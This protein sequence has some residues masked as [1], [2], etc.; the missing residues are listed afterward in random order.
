MLLLLERSGITGLADHA[1][2]SPVSQR[3]T[4]RLMALSDPTKPAAPGPHGVLGR[5]SV[6]HRGTIGCGVLDALG[7]VYILSNNHVLANIEW[8]EH[9]PDPEWIS[10]VHSTGAQ[11][12]PDRELSDFQVISFAR[13]VPT[14]STPRSP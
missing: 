12:R 13:T 10:P 3:V 1:R 6:D 2:R 11:P 8:R 5:T 7:R 14:R 4:G 9:R